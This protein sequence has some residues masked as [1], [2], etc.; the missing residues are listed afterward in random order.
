M[1]VQ[2]VDFTAL[3][4]LRMIHGLRGGSVLSSGS[5]LPAKAGPNIFN[6]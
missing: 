2:W 5:V 6:S 4:S 3:F 1:Q